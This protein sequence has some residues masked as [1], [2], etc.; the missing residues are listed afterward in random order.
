MMRALWGTVDLML[1]V[2]GAGAEDGLEELQDWLRHEPEFRGRVTPVDR[3]PDPGELGTTIDLLS[4]ALGSG[5]ALS[6]LAASLKGFFAQMRRSDLRIIVKAPDGG[7]VEID[8]KR[9][10]DAEVLIAGI[11]GRVE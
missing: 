1:C 5:G 9:V 7:S 11:L 4:V 3:P 6:V 8:A 2:E 10:K